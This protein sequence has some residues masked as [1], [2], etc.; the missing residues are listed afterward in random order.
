ME[1]KIINIKGLSINKY[2]RGEGA[3]DLHI[4][5]EVD[6]QK[7]IL[8]KRYAYTKAE[9]I[10]DDVIQT[11][12]NKFREYDSF[13]ENPLNQSMILMQNLEDVEEKM[14]NFIKRVHDKIRD[15]KSQRSYTNYIN[16]YNS[17]DGLGAQF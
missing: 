15:F 10:V 16:M 17:I 6:G 7:K 9:E 5:L 12:K 8:V 2:N 4:L 14:V 11:V 1:R 13:E 3:Y